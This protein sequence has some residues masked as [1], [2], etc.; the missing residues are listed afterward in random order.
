MVEHPKS[1]PIGIQR[2]VE[3]AR[4]GWFRL[5]AG[6]EHGRM[7]KLDRLEGGPLQGIN[8]SRG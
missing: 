4:K 1:S 5:S 8:V 3:N 7:T 2:I 6:S